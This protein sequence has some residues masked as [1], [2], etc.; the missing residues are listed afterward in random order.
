VDAKNREAIL[1]TFQ[2]EL[3]QTLIEMINHQGNMNPDR[4]NRINAY[5]FAFQIGRDYVEMTSVTGSGLRFV[6]LQTDQDQY[7]IEQ[8]LVA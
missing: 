3:H 5:C 2:S 7:Q 1:G 6:Q 8:L 4:G